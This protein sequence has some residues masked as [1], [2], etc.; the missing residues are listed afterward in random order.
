M[1]VSKESIGRF[2]IGNRFHEITHPQLWNLIQIEIFSKISGMRVGN[3]TW[4]RFPIK[5]LP[6]DSLLTPIAK[7]T[8]EYRYVQVWIIA[9]RWKQSPVG[10]FL[11][12]LQKTK[13]FWLLCKSLAILN[14]TGI[15][16]FIFLVTHIVQYLRSNLSD[17]CFFRW[18]VKLSLFEHLSVT[19]LSYT[20]TWR[21]G[22]VHETFRSVCLFAIYF[23]SQLDVESYRNDCSW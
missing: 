22:R 3:F 18:R 7:S 11:E 9:K 2:L 5:H 1:G 21:V 8:R 14:C 10:W 17:S 12:S 4:N 13:R 20:K 16:I 6:I 19:F 23:Q 15:C